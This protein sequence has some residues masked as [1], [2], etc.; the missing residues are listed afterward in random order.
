MVFHDDTTH[1]VRV[2]YDRCHCIGTSRDIARRGRPTDRATLV[3][4]RSPSGA[5]PRPNRA[6]I[7]G[8]PGPPN[9]DRAATII[10]A[11]R[12]LVWREHGDRI[13]KVGMHLVTHSAA[14]PAVAGRRGTTAATRRVAG[15]RRRQC[16]RSPCAPSWSFDVHRY[17]AR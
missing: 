6:P 17:G 2:L 1:I 16:G 14:S 11:R 3:A 13:S 5:G 10:Q 8:P 7:I 15:G 4:L 12:L 9:A